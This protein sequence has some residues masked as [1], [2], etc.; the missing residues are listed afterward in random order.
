RASRGGGPGGGGA[1]LGPPGVSGGDRRLRPVAAAV[2]RAGAGRLGRVAVAPG[3]SR[4]GQPRP[5]RAALAGDRPGLADRRRPADRG[6]V[7][8]AVAPAPHDARG[9]GAAFAGRTVARNARTTTAGQPLAGLGP[10]AAT[11][12]KGPLM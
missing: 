6:G 5:A 2:G 12:G 3:L 11:T 4:P 10:A 9:S 7:A 8:R 1:A